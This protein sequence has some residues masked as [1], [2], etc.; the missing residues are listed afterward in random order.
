[1]IENPKT[2]NKKESNLNLLNKKKKSIKSNVLYPNLQNWEKKNVSLSMLALAIWWFESRKG[3][4]GG[5]ETD[6]DGQ[7]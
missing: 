6:D 1:M 5:G 7:P 4:D 2:H 3:M